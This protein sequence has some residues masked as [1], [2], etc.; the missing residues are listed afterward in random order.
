MDKRIRRNETC[1]I[2]LPRC[3]F[4]FS[5]TRS[6]FIGY[7]FE[8]SSLEMSILKNLLKESEIETVEAGGTLAPAQ[9]AFCTKICS[10]II[11]SQ[12]CIVLLNNDLKNGKEIP[13]ANVNMEYGLMLGFNKY[14]IPFQKKSQSLPFNV[15]GLDTVKYTAR[16]FETK[17]KRAI[18]NAVKIT[19]QD[20]PNLAGFDQM[21][22]TF[23]LIKKAVVVRVDTLGDR[24]IFDL[25]SPIGFNLLTD[26][27]GLT[28]IFLGNFSS[29]R[30]E[31][32][33]WRVRV[34]NNIFDDRIKT[35]GERVKM[36]MLTKEQAE[37]LIP[38]LKKTRAWLL[39]TSKND[40]RKILKDL[41]RKPINLSTEI[42]SID[43]IRS[44]V[45]KQTS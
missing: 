10:K 5:A 12:F 39:V 14:I 1:I 19:R 43:E 37:T 45:E 4:V 3:D 41:K 15:S 17:A 33:L 8:E 11:N 34:L 16:D 36:N 28:Y 31:T 27:K 29:L 2:G 32:I 44:E 25:G 13:N 30:V 35:I 40:K 20:Q 7:G 6:C 24:N 22:A 9:N 38:M 42:F 18:E 23:L 26:F 21:L